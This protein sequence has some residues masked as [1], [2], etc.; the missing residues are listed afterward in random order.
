MNKSVARVVRFFL[1]Y[2]PEKPADQMSDDDFKLYLLLHS[3]YPPIGLMMVLPVLMSLAPYL[4]EWV[5]GSQQAFRDAFSALPFGEWIADTFPY[6][7]WAMAL[8]GWLVV[9]PTLIRRHRVRRYLASRG[10]NLF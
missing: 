7:A 2:R 1:G 3:A 8:L 10:V 9:L 5:Y 6:L 4:M